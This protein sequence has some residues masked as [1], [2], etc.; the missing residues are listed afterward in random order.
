MFEWRDEYSV[1]V[2]RIDDQH[3]KL[4][5]IAENTMQ[6]MADVKESDVYDDIIEQIESLTEYT[7]SHFRDEEIMLEHYNYP[8]LD[9]QQKEHKEIMD[10]LESVNMESLDMNQEGFLK[11]LVRFIGKWILSH[12]MGSDMD[13]KHYFEDNNIEAV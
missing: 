11:D 10:K 9:L 3:K 6:L 1:N 12:V 8:K 5:K 13:Y 4:L 7:R 2:K